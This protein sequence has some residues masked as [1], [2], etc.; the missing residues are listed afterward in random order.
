VGADRRGQEQEGGHQQFMQAGIA[1]EAEVHH[2]GQHH[3]AHA[4][5][6]RLGRP[7]QPHEEVRQPEQPDRPDQ[8]EHAAH[9]QQRAHDEF[10]NRMQHLALPSIR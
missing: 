5:R 7:M 8:H 3:P 10:R 9:Q 1:P 2:R 4:Q 6:G